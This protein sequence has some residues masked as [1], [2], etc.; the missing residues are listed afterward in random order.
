VPGAI[1]L[2]A[3]YLTIWWVALFAI[4]PLGVQSRHDAGLPNDGSDPGAPVDPKLKQ[5]FIT[6]TWVSAVIFA[7]FWLVLYFKLVDLSR[8]PGPNS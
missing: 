4:L 5:K 8:L 1:T 6:T 7:I 3:I 2:G